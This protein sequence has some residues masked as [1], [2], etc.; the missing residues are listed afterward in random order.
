[1]NDVMRFINVFTSDGKNKQISDIFLNEC[2]YWFA[3]ILF[4]RFVRENATIMF[5]KEAY[6][7]GTRIHGSVY[8][9]SGDVTANHKWIPWLD[10]QNDERKAKIVKK[11]IMF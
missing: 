1:M 6:H 10:V 11:Y 4:G 7:F 8:D 2:S 3:T 9:I 5:D